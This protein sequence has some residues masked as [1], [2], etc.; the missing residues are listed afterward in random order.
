MNEDQPERPVIPTHGRADRK[1]NQV[2]SNHVFMF[3]DSSFDINTWRVSEE[4]FTSCGPA[5]KPV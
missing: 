4:S 5:V 3:P 1:G 2:H